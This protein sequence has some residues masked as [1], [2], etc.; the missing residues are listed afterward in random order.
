MLNEVKHLLADSQKQR[1]SMR[2]FDCAHQDKV[3]H[4]SRRNHRTCDLQLAM[5]DPP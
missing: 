2:W 1:I 3:I 5:S 4:C